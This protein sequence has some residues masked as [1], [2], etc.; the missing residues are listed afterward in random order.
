MKRNRCV[1]AQLESYA[2]F[3]YYYICTYFLRNVEKPPQNVLIDET[4]VLSKF[5][6]KGTIQSLIIKESMHQSEGRKKVER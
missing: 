4:F 6:L 2:V 5:F 3:P 1:E